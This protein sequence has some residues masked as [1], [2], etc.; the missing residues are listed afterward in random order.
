MNEPSNACSSL[1][2]AKLMSTGHAKLHANGR[3]TF[4]KHTNETREKAE[5]ELV[6]QKLSKW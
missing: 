1:Y 4:Q 5:N 2:K 6:N 3:Y